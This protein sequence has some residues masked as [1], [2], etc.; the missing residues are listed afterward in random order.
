MRAVEVAVHGGPEALTL[1]ERE[2]PVPLP[3]D[4][5]VRNE[6][7]GVNFVDLQHTAGRPYPTQV[8][9][10]PG[11]EAAGTVSRTPSAA[12][13]DAGVHHSPMP[14]WPIGQR[15]V[16]FGHTTGVYAELT[17]VPREFV[18][19]VPD[20]VSLETAAAVMLTGTTAHVLTRVATQVGASHT[21]V[22][23]A[24]AGGTGWAVSALAAAAG[25][26]V[27]AIVSSPAKREAAASAGSISVVV[28]QGPE[29]LG[30]VRAATGGRGADFVFDAGGDATLDLSMRLL[31]DFG[32]LVLYGQSSGTGGLLDV[33]RLSGINGPGDAA[34]TTVKWVAAGHY[35]SSGTVRAAAAAAVFADVAAGVLQPRVAA[36]YPLAEAAAAHRTLADRATAGKVLLTLVPGE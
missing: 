23:H 27:V 4:V 16:H 33:G 15:V 14:E 31:A 5:L 36:R 7:I 28:G 34:S 3:G 1:V 10:V 26:H 32:T 19:P 29:L 9:F 20:D 25:A 2:D 35:L 24:G 18:V 12:M 22:V 21:V 11:T 13:S 6:Y 17:A 8:P 30:P